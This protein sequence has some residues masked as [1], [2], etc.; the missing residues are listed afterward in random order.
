MRKDSFA[1]IPH[2]ATP[3]SP[4]MLLLHLLR[5]LKQAG[6]VGRGFIRNGTGPLLNEF[7]QAGESLRRWS[8]TRP[9]R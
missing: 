6:V 7:L 4:P 9:R 5:L 8:T 3:T 2:D 1:Y